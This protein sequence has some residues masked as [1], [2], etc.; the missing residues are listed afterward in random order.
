MA[1]STC[2]ISLATWLGTGMSPSVAAP[3]G[4]SP[5]GPSGI[6]VSS[7]TA[8]LELAPLQLCGDIT[9]GSALGMYLSSNGYVS[10]Q[11]GGEQRS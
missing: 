10:L 7:A 9:E 11:L 5:Y 4:D 1:I 8:G 6:V 2:D 3:P